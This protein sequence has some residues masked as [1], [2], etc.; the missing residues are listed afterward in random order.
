MMMQPGTVMTQM[1]KASFASE[2]V[3]ARL[4]TL[5]PTMLMLAMLTLAAAL[6]AVMAQEQAALRPQILWFAKAMSAIKPETPVMLQEMLQE[7]AARRPQT[8]LVSWVRSSPV[9]FS[10]LQAG[11]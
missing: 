6:N 5:Q 11:S 2:V 10:A 3:A 4:Q 7:V 8:L 1:T 9:A